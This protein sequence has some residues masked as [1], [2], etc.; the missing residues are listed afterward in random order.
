VPFLQGHFA[1]A[2]KPCPPREFL[3]RTPHEFAKVS[4]LPIAF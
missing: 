4:S 2:V 3:L 1:H